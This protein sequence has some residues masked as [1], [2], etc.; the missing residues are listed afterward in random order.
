MI[1]ALRMMED[2][3]NGHVYGL[4]SGIIVTKCSIWNDI[5]RTLARCYWVGVAVHVR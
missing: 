4:L 2:Y 3:E 1:Y 5:W